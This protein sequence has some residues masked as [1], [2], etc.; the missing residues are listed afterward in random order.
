MKRMN[1]VRTALLFISESAFSSWT[2]LRAVSDG[3]F[4][5][6]KVWRSSV[7]QG[8]DEFP[9][10]RHTDGHYL[11]K[12]HNLLRLIATVSLWNFRAAWNFIS[13]LTNFCVT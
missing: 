5:Y 8:R 3:K 13:K 9:I 7:K 12:C 6:D 2:A 1:P 10:R 11:Q 4:I